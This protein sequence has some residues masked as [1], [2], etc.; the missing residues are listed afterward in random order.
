MG[1]GKMQGQLITGVMV[2]F[3]VKKI[4]IHL[5]CNYTSY[6]FQVLWEC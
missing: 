2:Y 6:K 1:E 3:V 5:K 4:M